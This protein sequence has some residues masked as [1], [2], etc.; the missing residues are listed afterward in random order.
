M[1]ESISTQRKLKLALIG[2]TGAIGLEIVDHL[3]KDAWFSE[4]VLLCR[5]ELEDWKQE[6]F[7][8]KL[9]IVRMENFDKFDDVK[10]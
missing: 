10:G 5:R 7:T 2:S 4:V 3:K 1:V 8:P 6:N 9:T